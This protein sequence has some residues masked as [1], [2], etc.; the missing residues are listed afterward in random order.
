MISS[1]I[2]K[3]QA[4]DKFCSA[5]RFAINQHQ[6]TRD[7][8]EA[9]PIQDLK[10]SILA[11]AQMSPTDRDHKRGPFNLL[12]R[13]QTHDLL[14]EATSPPGWEETW[15]GSIPFFGPYLNFIYLGLVAYR[16]KYEDVADFLAEDL[17]KEDSRWISKK[18]AMKEKSKKDV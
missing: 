14:L 13:P 10:W 3:V 2:S 12:D 1:P 7:V 17:E 8:V 16:T 15:L 5:P 4:I 18:V 6:A 11:V 9:V